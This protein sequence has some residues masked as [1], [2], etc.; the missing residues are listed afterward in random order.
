MDEHIVELNEKFLGEI[1]NISLRKE[2]KIEED[3]LKFNSK[4]DQTQYEND[5]ITLIELA[6]LCKK[7]ALK[8][9]FRIMS[10]S[11]TNF[12]ISYLFKEDISLRL[13]QEKCINE[14]LENT[15]ELSIICMTQWLYFSL[16]GF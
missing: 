13:S 16:N 4:Y 14:I 9:N 2:V 10:Y 7:W 15:E 6:Y 11:D 12:G 8:R 3:I 1:L 5:E